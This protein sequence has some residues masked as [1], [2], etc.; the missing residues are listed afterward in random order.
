MNSH[1]R[2]EITR[3]ESTEALY[4]EIYA[5]LVRLARQDA[6]DYNLGE[7]QSREVEPTPLA[8][9][10]QGPPMATSE[11]ALGPT[12]NAVRTPAAICPAVN[13]AS[14]DPAIGTPPMSLAANLSLEPGL[15][16]QV[17][18]LPV[19]PAPAHPPVAGHQIVSTWLAHEGS[20][21]PRTARLYRSAILFVLMDQGYPELEEARQRLNRQDQD[22]D[23]WV[24]DR[25][26]IRRQ[27]RY[28]RRHPRTSAQKAK[29]FSEEDALHLL[30]ALGKARSEWSDATATWISANVL[31]GL[32]PG[33]WQRARVQQNDAGEEVLTVTNAKWTNG[34]AHG[35]DRTLVLDGLTAGQRAVILRQIEITSSFVRLDQFPHYYKQCRQLLQRI[36]DRLWPDRLRHPTLSTGRHVF[37]A[38]AKSV[39]GKI[40]V[41]AMLGHASVESAGMH[42]A[43]R[44]RGG[45]CGVRPS[46][47]DI[48]A[49]AALN[50]GE[51]LHPL[52]PGK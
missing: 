25:D 21:A 35:A 17:G 2:P 30:E 9:L 42:Y 8:D 44:R 10:G 18:A 11:A 33:E 48:D 5:R 1:G 20:W 50:P 4:R 22:G 51:A 14:V 27:Q 6:L 3:T 23:A 28:L 24:H 19:A 45:A 38:N 36:A 15:A 47:R 39:F 37:T 49:V 16:A 29:Y 13:N 31:T 52:P 7:V 26:Q 34:R 32:R 46:V 12:L 41:A 43:R 40:E